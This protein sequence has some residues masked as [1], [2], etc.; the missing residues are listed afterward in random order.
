MS[1]SR[2][3]KLTGIYYVLFYMRRLSWEVVYL[4]SKVVLK[5]EGGKYGKNVKIPP[6]FMRDVDKIEIGDNVGAGEHCS[7]FGGNGIKI[8]N[9]VMIASYVSFISADH[10]IN[11]RNKYMNEQGHRLGDKPIIIDDDVW[12]GT[13]AIILKRVHIGKGAVVGAGAVVTKDVPPYAIVAG[14]PAKIIKFR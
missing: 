10:D 12:I 6:A 8:G 9:N 2:V 13:H 14:N 3:L 4:K 1:F 7:F 11:D 5:L